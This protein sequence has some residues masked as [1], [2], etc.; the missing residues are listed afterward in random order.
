MCFYY[1]LSKLAMRYQERAENNEILRKMNLVNGFKFPVMPVITEN[2]MELKKWGLIPFW[3]KDEKIRQNT[4]NARNDTIFEKPS[5]K[6]RIM[7]HRCII[8]ATGYIDWQHR[9]KVKQPYYIH[10]KNQD[11]FSFAGIWDNWKNPETGQTVSTYAIITT[12]AN[13]LL[14]EIHNTKKRQPLILTGDIEFSWLDK[15]LTKSDIESYFVPLGDEHFGAYPIKPFNLTDENSVFERL[16]T[17][18]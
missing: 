3:S 15:D 10:L 7:T 4:L 6:N 11:T 12:D 17:L 13:P 1:S 16:E 14:A 2:G 9:G 5:F 18:F 8:P